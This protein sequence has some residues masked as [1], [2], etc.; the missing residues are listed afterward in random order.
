MKQQENIVKQISVEDIQNLAGKYLS[1]DRMYY[2]I[3]GDAATQLDRL[4]GL[5]FGKPVLL[6]AE[7][8]AV[9]E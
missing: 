1:T 2:L 9:M 3:V 4:E 6:N 5:G 8:A 7:E